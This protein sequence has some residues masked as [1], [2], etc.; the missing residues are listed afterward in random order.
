MAQKRLKRP[1]RRKFTTRK[2]LRDV[3]INQNPT[4]DVRPRLTVHRTN[5]QIYAQVIDDVKGETI[6][7]ASS[8]DKDASLK[9]GGNKDAAVAVG[10]LIAQR[11]KKAGVEKVQF[12]RGQYIY[13]GRVKALAE[14][15][16][17][18]GLEF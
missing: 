6:A 15:A 8:V 4:R 13:H 16:R 3:N 17:E 10:K 18:G 12:D 14:G 1:E 5:M 7:S 2:K 9:N 11:A